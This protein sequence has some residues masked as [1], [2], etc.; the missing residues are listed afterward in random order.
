MADGGMIGS[1]DAGLRR[2]AGRERAGDGAEF[3][4]QLV[5]GAGGVGGDRPEELDQDGSLPK[6]FRRRW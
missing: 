5:G 2:A 4:D 3:A 1:E 6:R